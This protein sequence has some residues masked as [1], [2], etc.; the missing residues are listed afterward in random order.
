MQTSPHAVTLVNHCGHRR[1]EVFP[2]PIFKK[3]LTQVASPL[4]EDA[5]SPTF[6]LRQY[7][8][9]EEY[10]KKEIKTGAIPV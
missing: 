1:A 6:I 8:L 3:Y 5:F 9:Q 10:K 7:W 2:P 4:L